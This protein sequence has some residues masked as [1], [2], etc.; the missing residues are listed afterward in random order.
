MALFSFRHSVKTFSEKRTAESR[1]AKSGQ[2]AAHLRYISRPQA[3]R[4]VMRE[5]LTGPTDAKTANEAEQAA[6]KRKG[7]VCEKFIVALPVEASAEQREALAKAFA[8]RLTGG[9]AGY[10]AAIHDKHGNDKANPH[11]HLVAFDVMVRSGGRGRPKS[12]LGMARKNAV[13]NTAKIWTDL[14]NTMMRK[15]GFGPESMISNL[16]LQNRGIDRIPTIHEGAAARAMAT[17]GKEPERKQQWQG[18]DEGHSRAEANKIIREI[19]EAKGQIHARKYRLG[20]HD[21]QG[22]AQRDWGSTECRE[23]GGRRSK[24]IGSPAPPFAATGCP[25]EGNGNAGR[26]ATPPVFAEPARRQRP[27]RGGNPFPLSRLGLRRRAGRRYGVRRIYR[28][29]IWLRDTLRARLLPIGGQSRLHPEPINAPE[30]LCER[31]STRS[32]HDHERDL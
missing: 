26:S 32:S 17:E 1:V 30:V 3:A 16:S 2:T 6:Q 23:S 19:N 4:T 7:R 9:V 27:G 11:F 31:E 13:E 29:L 15:W 10:V 24:S 22:R 12:T 5:R 21:D 18:I 25:Q 28:E 14:H 8:E 20:R